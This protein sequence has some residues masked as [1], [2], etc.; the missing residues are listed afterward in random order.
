MA[1]K[2]IKEEVMKLIPMIDYVL[3]LHG[4]TY[5][6]LIKAIP[7]TFH[8]LSLND[9][10][11]ETVNKMLSNDAIMSR[12]FKEYAKFLKQTPELWMFVPCDKEGNVLEEPDALP[13]N[14]DQHSRFSHLE[15]LEQYQKAKERVLFKG[16]EIVKLPKLKLIRCH[17]AIRVEIARKYNEEDYFHINSDLKTLEDL[18]HLGLELNKEI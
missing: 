16:F 9:S 17:N 2:P 8:L 5:S 14:L 12:L 4:M 7:N 11:E 3:E 10:K 1:F 15:I 6:E 13:E 18:T